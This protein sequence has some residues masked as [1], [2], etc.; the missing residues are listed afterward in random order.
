MSAA[1]VFVRN[2]EDRIVYWSAGA[3]DLYGYTK[4]EALGRVSHQLLRTI[5]PT[6]LG[7][8]RAEFRKVGSW[9]G[10]LVHIGK[11][12][13]LRIVASHWLRYACGDEEM[14]AEIDNSYEPRSLDPELKG[15]LQE[16][17]AASR[18]KDQFLAVLSHEL[19]GPLNSISIW[20]DALL[21]ALERQQIDQRTLGEGLTAIHRGVHAQAALINDLLDV[22]RIVAGKF[23]INLEVVELGTIV[24]ACAQTFMEQARSKKIE[25]RL[26]PA[27]VELWIR[28]DRV[29][30]EQVLTNLLNNALRYTDEG[31]QIELETRQRE[32]RAEVIVHDSGRGFTTDEHQR[33]FQAFSQLEPDSLQGQAGLGLGLVISKHVVESHAGTIDAK[34]SGVGKGADFVVSLPLI[35]PP[36]L[37]PAEPAAELH[38]PP[39]ARRLEGKK[40]LVLDDDEETRKA[41]EYVLQM[42]GADLRMS[43]HASEGWSTLGNWHPDCILCNIGLAGLN[44]YEFVAWSKAIP[45]LRPVPMIAVTAYSSD[46]DIQRALK[47]GFAAHVG[48]PL[49]PATLLDTIKQVLAGK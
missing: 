8:I 27:A 15:R 26:K 14:V 23:Q 13:E 16:S 12:G 19:R 37:K 49:E 41:L 6:P 46:K 35:G 31:G 30:L 33:L 47:A 32:H 3:Q 18:A 28:G 34:S 40:L 29:R 21:A 44:G 10:D 36:M 9:Q 20:T 11:A 1:H 4:A 7:Q 17:E 43:S 5:F 38:K 39:I 24:A 2:S 42:A 25:F 45:E 48:K 22:S